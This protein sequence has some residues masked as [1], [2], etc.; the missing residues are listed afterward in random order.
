MQ[1]MGRLLSGTVKPT[2]SLPH[3]PRWLGRPGQQLMAAEEGKGDAREAFQG[4]IS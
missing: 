3:L 1:K 4:N 2:S